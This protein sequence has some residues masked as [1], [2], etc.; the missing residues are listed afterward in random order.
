MR[1]HDDHHDDE[2]SGT[3]HD[4]HRRTHDEHRRGP[5]TTTL[6]TTTHV[7]TGRPYDDRAGRL[8]RDHPPRRHAVR[9]HR[10]VSRRT[11]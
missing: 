2:P 3:G 4:E 11:T 8:V 6:V 1:E 9:R 7:G 5:R 10:H